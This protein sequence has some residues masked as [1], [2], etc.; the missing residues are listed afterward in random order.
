MKPALEQ[1]L[2]NLISSG[3][4]ANFRSYSRSKSPCAVSLVRGGLVVVD[5]S[6]GITMVSDLSSAVGLP[7]LSEQSEIFEASSSH[8]SATAP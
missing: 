7:V 1:S 8:I 4:F 6:A 2:N 3:R 5:K